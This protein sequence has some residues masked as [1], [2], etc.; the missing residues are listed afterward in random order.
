MFEFISRGRFEPNLESVC[1]RLRERRDAMLHALEQSFPETASWSRP[2]GGYF[3]WL[4]LDSGVSA[5]DLA[6][7]AD[8]RGV[9]IVRGQDFFPASGQGVSSARLAFSYEPPERITEG[10]A[11]LA[12]LLP[13]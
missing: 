11:R 8:D 1:A 7:R 4:D 5:S 3:V 2:Q 13:R 6:A 12:E 9:S 10:I